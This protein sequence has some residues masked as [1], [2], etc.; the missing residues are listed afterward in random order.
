ML[1][2][3]QIEHVLARAPHLSVGLVGDLFLD[4]YLDIDAALTE[5]SIETGLDAFQVVGVRPQPGALGTVVGNLV[6]LGVGRVLPVTL[7]GDDGEGYELRRAL[8]ALPGVDGR[9]VV[10][11]AARRTPT[12]TKPM[13]CEPGHAPR[14]LNRLDIKN[15]YPT[16][17]AVE[18]ALL[19]HLTDLWPACDVWLALDQ[20]SEPDCGVL[21]RRVRAALGTLAGTDPARF[22]LA[23]SR[24]RLGLFENVAYKPN[25]AE[26]H[27]VLR[28]RRTTDIAGT[29]RRTS[30]ASCSGPKTCCSFCR[31]WAGKISLII[32]SV[33]RGVSLRWACAMKARLRFMACII[34][35]LKP[36]KKYCL[37]A[38]QCM[39]VLRCTR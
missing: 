26:A 21:T 27:G 35:C 29:W 8:A 14:E 1:T 23:D 5:P 6:A 4:R 25:M 36:M 3:A 19:G 32:R 2:E 15:R 38:V 39:W 31:S 7:A 33:C 22:V 9:F 24:E 10:T 37:W 17:V 28:R 11:D 18:D 16:P 13:L 34:R 30:G 12:Y 20:V